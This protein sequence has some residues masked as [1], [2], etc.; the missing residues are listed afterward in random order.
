M[1]LMACNDDDDVDN[2]SGADDMDGNHGDR[3]CDGHAF[4]MMTQ[5]ERMM[6]VA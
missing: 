3:A 4:M 2:G 5:S 6:P 1:C